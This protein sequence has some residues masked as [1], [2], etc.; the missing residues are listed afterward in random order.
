MNT[1]SSQECGCGETCSCK[2]CVC[3]PQAAF[4][5][6]LGNETRL[7]LLSVLRSG[8]RNVTELAER[9]GMEQTL[10]SHGLKRLEDAGLVTSERDGKFKVYSLAIN[11][12]PLM[13]LVDEHAKKCCQDQAKA[14]CCAEVP[15]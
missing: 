5:D 14:C 15:S 13:A 7:Y 10:V 3:G 6:T 8:P 2:N 11:I 9:T 12:E 4:F 1:D